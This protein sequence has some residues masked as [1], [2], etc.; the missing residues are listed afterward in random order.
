MVTKNH[1]GYVRHALRFHRAALRGGTVAAIGALAVG[2]LALTA[3]GSSSG[4]DPLESSSASQVAQQA[5]TDLK[6]APTVT[7]NGSVSQGGTSYTIN[8]QTKKGTGCT[9]TVGEGGKGSL[10]LVVI[11]KTVWIKPDTTMWKSFLGGSQASQAIALINGRYLE[12]S[13]KDASSLASLISLCNPN[14]LVSGVTTTRDL[15]KGTITTVNGERVLPLQDKAHGG[16]VDVTDESVPEITELSGNGSGDTGKIVF[17][18]GTPVTVTAPPASQTL[19]G[20]QFG[21]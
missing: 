8:L 4:R 2:M 17:M 7:M 19:S 21:F 16:T 12:S 11:G 15:S 13:A 1:F 6:A 14:S 3:C 10:A 9:G 5:V 18:E 20:S